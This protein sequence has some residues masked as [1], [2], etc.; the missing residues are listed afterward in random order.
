M[1]LFDEDEMDCEC[2]G[3][4]GLIFNGDFDVEYPVCGAEYSLIDDSIW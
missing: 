2:C 3:H 1:S 4:V